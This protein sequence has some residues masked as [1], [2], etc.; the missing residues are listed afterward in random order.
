MPIPLWLL[1]SRPLGGRGG[2][3]SVAPASATGVQHRRPRPG[4]R[5]AGWR[6]THPCDR[7]GNYP[8]P[9]VFLE[10][11]LR[12]VGGVVFGEPGPCSQDSVVSTSNHRVTVMLLALPLSFLKTLEQ[13]WANVA[14]AEPGSFCARPGRRRSRAQPLRDVCLGLFC[15]PTLPRPPRARRWA[16]S[17]LRPAWVGW[18]TCT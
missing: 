3:R 16:G 10:P 15:L 18:E 9:R 2:R 4:R 17:A 7:E 6:A 5:G 8:F 1:A 14:Q 13:I 11:P 12:T